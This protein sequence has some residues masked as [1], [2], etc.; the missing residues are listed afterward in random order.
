MPWMSRGNVNTAV[1]EFYLHFSLSLPTR[2]QQLPTLLAQQCWEL[3]HPFTDVWRVGTIS[4]LETQGQ[5]VGTIQCSWWKSTVRSRLASLDLTVN[6]H[7]EPE[8]PRTLYR[9][10]YLPLG[11]RGW[12]NF[13]SRQISRLCGL[14]IFSLS[15]YLSPLNLLI[16]IFKAL[17]LKPFF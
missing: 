1:V 13:R 6:F 2:T 11:L 5:I 3:L 7:H 9:P 15:L 10:D 16:A 8:W 4:S 12:D 17:F 14:A